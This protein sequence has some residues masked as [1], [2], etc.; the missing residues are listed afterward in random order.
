[1]RRAVQVVVR[2][3]ERDPRLRAERDVDELD[4]HNADEEKRADGFD[5]RRNDGAAAEGRHGGAA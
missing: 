2:Q 3:L 4:D 1:M 5:L